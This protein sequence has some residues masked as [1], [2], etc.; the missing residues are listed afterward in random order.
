MQSEIKTR[1]TKQ[2]PM[3]GLLP[4]ALEYDTS[5]SRT[6]ISG[7]SPLKNNEKSKHS[8]KNFLAENNFLSEKNSRNHEHENIDPSEI[9]QG[10]IQSPMDN[11]L[12]LLATPKRV[13]NTDIENSE[14]TS[15]KHPK[16]SESP[17]SMFVKG[18]SPI[19]GNLLSSPNLIFKHTGMTHRYTIHCSI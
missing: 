4:R 18:L 6:L 8:N 7:K 9:K 15:N 2:K 16:P 3:P 14:H 10:L 12:Q 5:S 17:F 11:K 13:H 19:H 1:A